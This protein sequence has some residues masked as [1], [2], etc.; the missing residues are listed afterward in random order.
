MKSRK[1]N[2]NM[3]YAQHNSKVVL[4]Q[5]MITDKKVI[6][7]LATFINVNNKMKK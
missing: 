4:I 1:L 6:Q 2:K 5:I 3:K 7:K